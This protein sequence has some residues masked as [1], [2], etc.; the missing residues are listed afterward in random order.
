MRNVTIATLRLLSG[1]VAVPILALL[2]ML[3]PWLRVRLLVVASHRFGHLALEPE[4]ELLRQ[5]LMPRQRR[6]VVVDLWSFGS[7]R[8]QSN[9]YLVKLWA[10]RIHHPPSWVTGALVRGGELFKFLALE[11]PSLSIHGP[12]N[13]LDRGQR[14]CPTPTEF[15]AEEIRSLASVGFDPRKPYVALVVRDADHY[16]LRGEQ[17]DE[18]STLLN[19]DL[20]SFV[21]A[22]A[23]LVE[24]DL[25]V[26]RLGGPSR[27]SLPAIDGGVD[28]ANSAIRTAELDVKLATFCKFAVSTQT[29]PDAVVLLARQPV[30]Y[31]DVLRCSQFFFG[32]QLATWCPMR[33]KDPSDQRFW[34][35]KRLC[36]SNLLMA[37]NTDEF[38]RSGLQFIRSDS[39]QIREYVADFLSELHHSADEETLRS[40][41][42]VNNTLQLAMGERGQ[43]KFGNIVA[44]ISRIWLEK[45][46]SWWMDASAPTK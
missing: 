7:A 38:N 43:Q 5:K 4:M 41:M 39:T 18:S 16:L 36:A 35:L 19:A 37:K 31:V 2:R 28:Y 14:Q 29:G 1:V 26:I 30:L 6:P 34:S 44:P 15:S 32:T 46:G 9:A 3:R 42:Q 21:A 12:K 27:Q 40:R 25:Q 33:I 23:Y 45:H 13:G 11:R 10:E 22:S 20:S 17:E 24:N 8:I